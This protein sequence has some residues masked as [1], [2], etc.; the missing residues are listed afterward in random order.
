MNTT[1]DCFYAIS[2]FLKPTN[3][4]QYDTIYSSEYT[5]E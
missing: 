1:S 3:K 4:E 5:N 2:Q